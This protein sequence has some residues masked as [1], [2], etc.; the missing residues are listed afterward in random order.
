MRLPRK[1]FSTFGVAPLLEPGPIGGADAGGGGRSPL[2]LL[3]SS[4]T[5]F[6]SKRNSFWM[7]LPLEHASSARF[8]FD[9]EAVSSPILAPAKSPV[10]KHVSV[11]IVASSSSSS[12]VKSFAVLVEPFVAS[13][14]LNSQSEHG[15]K[16]PLM[17]SVASLLIGGI[18]AGLSALI[19]AAN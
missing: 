9:E 16:S 11:E 3:T 4:R 12:V 1:R 8:K 19:L 5:F 14:V 2:R 15:V 6:M 7:C 17:S 10:L 13:L 18:R